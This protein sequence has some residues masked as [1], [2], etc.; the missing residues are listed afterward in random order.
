MMLANLQLRAIQAT[1]ARREFAFGEYLALRLVTSPLAFLAIASIALI[2]GYSRETALVILA[3]GMVKVCQSLS[4]VFHGVLQQRGYMDRIARSLMLRGFLAFLALVMLLVLTGSI[5]WGAVGVALVYLLVLVVYDLRSARIVLHWAPGTE[6][7]LSPRWSARR[8]LELTWLALP[9]GFVMMLISLNGNIPRYAIER[10]L[11]EAELGIYAAIAYLQAAGNAVVGALGQS[12][13]PRLAEYY[14]QGNL[15]AFRRLLVRLL[16][17]GASLG[18]GGVLVALVSGQQILALLY[19]S[20][21]AEYPE[22]FVCLMAA[23]GIAYVA[24]FL[25]YGMTAT[26][27]FRPQLLIFAIVAGVTAFG[28]ILLVPSA[29]VLGAAVASIPPAVINCGLSGLVVLQALRKRAAR[30]ASGA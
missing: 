30:T 22:S 17:I 20:E 6:D 19:G 24:S 11:G 7:P 21:Y 23:S 9:M 15:R 26:R 5:V 16:G 1:D 10:S 3:L 8:L 4:D 14:A 18:V 29:G 13:S 2:A 12:A 28:C 27:R 25:G